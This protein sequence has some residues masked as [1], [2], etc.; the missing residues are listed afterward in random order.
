[1]L[2]VE[3]DNPELERLYR[4]PRYSGDYSAEVVRAF[5]K[6]MQAICSAQDERDLYALKSNHFEKLKGDRSGER[7][8]RLNAQWRLIVRLE[9]EHP[10]KR[11]VVLSVEDYH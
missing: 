1:M 9:G 4:D 6:R 8:L 5:R 3:F 2:I 10:E 11:V 7:S